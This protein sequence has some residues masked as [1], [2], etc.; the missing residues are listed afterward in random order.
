MAAFWSKPVQRGMGALLVPQLGREDVGMS[1]AAGLRGRA[2]DKLT[3]QPPPHPFPFDAAPDAVQVGAGG[4]GEC[5]DRGD[6][7][8]AQ[9][10]FQIGPNA[11][12]V[13]QGQR[14]QHLRQI[15]QFNHHQTIG[16]L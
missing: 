14:V 10:L 13:A 2:K 9:P 15:G 11:R 4:G 3:P 1:Q 7:A 12:Q 5:G 6:A 8:G 16:F